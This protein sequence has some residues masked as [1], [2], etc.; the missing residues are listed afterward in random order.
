MA[1]TPFKS[2]DNFNMAGFNE[3]ITEADNTYV[4]KTGG[5]MSGA[6]SMGNN[7]ITDVASPTSAGDV[8]TKGYVD[9][10][11]IFNYKRKLIASNYFQNGRTENTFTMPSINDIDGE[12][13]G[14]YYEIELV[15]YKQS[16]NAG[17]IITICNTGYAS[18][19]DLLS[20]RVD[21]LTGV[22]IKFRNCLYSM[23]SEIGTRLTYAYFQN[24]M[25]IG[26]DYNNPVYFGQPSR[27]LFNG[28]AGIA[29]GRINYNIYLF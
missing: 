26:K 7:K 15:N 25:I 6:L 3:K 5:S 4:A 18:G 21:N 20:F 17:F 16:N 13:N 11:N 2:S 1:V 9:G 27:V 12:F 10:N 22:N 8:A 19:V 28:G 24:N 29:S 14:I 23:S